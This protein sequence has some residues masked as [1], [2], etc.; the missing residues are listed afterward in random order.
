MAFSYYIYYRVAQAGDAALAVGKL[1]SAI[2]D[3]SGVAG[4]VLKKR[5][6]PA[7]WMEIYEGVSDG[8]QFEALLAGL[9]ESL[10]FNSVLAAGSTR[11]TECFEDC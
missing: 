8:A 10:N 6:E 5:G 4:R 11:K 2:R 1:Q 9:V 7:M 3:R